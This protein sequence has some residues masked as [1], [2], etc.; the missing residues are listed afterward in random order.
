MKHLLNPRLSQMYRKKIPTNLILTNEMYIN[1]SIKFNVFQKDKV[2][3]FIF[4]FLGGNTLPIFLI[5]KKQKQI[6]TIK[7]QWGF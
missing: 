1:K 3:V 6:K 4:Y 7:Y 2:W 5:P